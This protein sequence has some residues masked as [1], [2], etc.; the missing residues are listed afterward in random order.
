MAAIKQQIEA[1]NSERST[2]GQRIERIMLVG[3]L[4]GS[5][6]VFSVLDKQFNSPRMKYR[7]DV[8]K[9][10]EDSST[11][12]SRGAI[13]CALNS[14]A[15]GERPLGCS[16]GCA[17]DEDYDE[18]IHT[19]DYDPEIHGVTKTYLDYY[20][21]KVEIVEDRVHLLFRMDEMVPSRC[22]RSMRGFRCVSVKG[23]VMI[24]ETLYISEG[25][26]KDHLAVRDPRNVFKRLGSLEV[27]LPYSDRKDVPIVRDPETG[28]CYMLMEY[29]ILDKMDY[30][31]LTY[32]II[33]PR[34]GR[35]PAKGWGK[36]PIRKP[37]VLNCAA[38]FDVTGQRAVD[39][40]ALPNGRLISASSNGDASALNET[41]SDTAVS[42]GLTARRGQKRS[43]LGNYGRTDN[44]KKRNKASDIWTFQ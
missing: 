12:I 34:N 39:M 43:F 26:S 27:P 33:L 30:P 42:S 11:L 40:P 21:R 8:V 15:I 17:W 24:R 22:I 18:K 16:I 2:N 14:D 13:L 10:H 1:F 3:G 35:F 29:E 31:L 7:I 19:E 9:P 37:A 6:H 28:I 32:E 38:A 36:N 41:K 5:P 4:S 23:K 44:D 25:V 20:D